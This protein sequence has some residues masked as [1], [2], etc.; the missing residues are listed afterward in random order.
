MKESNGQE[1]HEG[2]ELGDLSQSWG[3]VGRGARRETPGK[4]AGRLALLFR[5]SPSFASMLRGPPAQRMHPSPITLGLQTPQPPAL[6]VLGFSP[7]T[8]KRPALHL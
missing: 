5:E 3:Q 2:E 1:W 8:K 7:W 4:A 6:M